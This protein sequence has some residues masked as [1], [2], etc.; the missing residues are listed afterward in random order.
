MTDWERSVRDTYDRVAG[1]YATRI[2]DE[3]AG[4][5][6][7][8]AILDRLAELALPIGPV[9]DLGCGPGRAY[10]LAVKPR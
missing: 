4:K 5:P 8:R 2:F 3:L 6:F 1:E 9:C 7:D 10:L